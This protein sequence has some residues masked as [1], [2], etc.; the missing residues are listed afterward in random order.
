M[1]D[2]YV[3]TFEIKDVKTL[4]GDHL[5]RAIGESSALPPPLPRL[6]LTLP[7]S[8]ARVVSLQAV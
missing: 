5:S 7:L 1:D 8:H 4:H 3:D 6:A 2:L